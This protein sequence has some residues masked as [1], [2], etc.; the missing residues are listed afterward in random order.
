MRRPNLRIKGIDENEDYQ[1]KE[2]VNIFNKIIEENFLNLKNNAHGCTRS[3][4]N[5]KRTGPE[6]KFLPIHNNQNNKCTK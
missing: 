6:K 3:L 4:E 2:S 5:S 1:L